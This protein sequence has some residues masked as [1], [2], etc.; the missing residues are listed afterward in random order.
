M[1]A[2]DGPAKVVVGYRETAGLRPDSRSDTSGLHDPGP[3][4]ASSGG[5]DPLLE[6]GTETAGGSRTSARKWDLCLQ[7]TNTPGLALLLPSVFLSQ[8]PIS[9]THSQARG[10]GNFQ[11]LGELEKGGGVRRVG[12]MAQVLILAISL[13]RGHLDPLSYG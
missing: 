12:P 5:E 2:G 4:C 3:E 10:Q 6:M 13:R 11:P 1:F 9:W 8:L 7:V